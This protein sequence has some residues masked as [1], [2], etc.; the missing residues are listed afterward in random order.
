M[1]KIFKPK[2]EFDENG[3]IL[4]NNKLECVGEDM[5]NV[6]AA[7]DVC[8]II[9]DYNKYPFFQQMRLWTQVYN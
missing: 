1:K 3:Y 8:H 2:F 4:V 6:Y 9:N 7:G 5:K